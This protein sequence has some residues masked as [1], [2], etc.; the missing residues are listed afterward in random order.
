MVW[1]HRCYETSKAGAADSFHNLVECQQLAKRIRSF[2]DKPTRA[3]TLAHS[4]LNLAKKLEETAISLGIQSDRLIRISQT[5][6][7]R[8]AKTDY[9]EQPTTIEV[10]HVNLEQLIRFLF[11]L[12][13]QE[14]RVPDLRITAPRQELSGA[15]VWNVE[16]TIT[17]LIFAPTAKP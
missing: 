1:S 13:E 8:L 16:A 11:A 9:Q 6:P 17:Q 7:Q 4:Q 2:R 12:K 14:L 15:E 3:A 10:Q 5:S